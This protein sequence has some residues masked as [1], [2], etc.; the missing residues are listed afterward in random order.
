MKSAGDVLESKRESLLEKL[1]SNVEVATTVM[2][3][4]G[5]IIV[6]CAKT[7]K[8]IAGVRTS[9]ISE[10]DGNFTFKITYGSINVQSIGLWKM[11][12]GSVADYI[13]SRSMHMARAL[14]ANPSLIKTFEDLVSAIDRFC[15]RHRI[16]FSDF[17]IEKRIVTRENVCILKT[18]VDRWGR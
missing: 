2:A 4:L 3:F 18:K 1:V 14:N 13:C 7:G 9:P 10:F 5:H 11:D 15:D 16:S 6:Q 17:K 12:N 8:Q